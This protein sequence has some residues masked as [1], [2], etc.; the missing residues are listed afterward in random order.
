[1]VLLSTSW[2]LG[3]NLKITMVDELVGECEASATV[4][5]KCSSC[6]GRLVFQGGLDGHAWTQGE[7]LVVVPMVCRVCGEGHVFHLKITG[8]L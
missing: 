5:A 6:G 1:M 2:D 8:D 4:A 7:E 3:M